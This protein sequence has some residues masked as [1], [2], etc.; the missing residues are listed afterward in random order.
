MR[1]S[2]VKIQLSVPLNLGIK[3]TLY[4]RLRW[5]LCPFKKIEKHIP[6][7]G[8]IV[9]I[10]CGYGLLAN[11][12]VLRSSKREVMGKDLSVKRISIAQ[13]TTNNRKRIQFKYMNALDLQT[14][15]YNAI[16]MSD[17]LHHIDY[18]AQEQL[19]VHCYQKL[20][21]GGLLIIEEVDNKPF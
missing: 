2:E 6:K 21:P 14:R 1:V 20:L 3:V 8:T 12:L 4:V 7:E 13:K 10:G 19:L 11:L 9:D 17:F 18:G 16:V 15:K 5:R